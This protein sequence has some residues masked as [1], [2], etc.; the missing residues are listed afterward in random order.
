MVPQCGL[1]S[2]TNERHIENSGPNTNLLKT[3]EMPFNMQNDF[4]GSLQC[5]ADS[6]R[7]QRNFWGLIGGN[8]RVQVL[9]P[10]F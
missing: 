1:R 9:L 10:S 2:L 8:K 4:I 5:H 3:P 6:D 7:C